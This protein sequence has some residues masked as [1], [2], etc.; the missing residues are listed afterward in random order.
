M[1]AKKFTK[2]QTEQATTL[3][4][5]SLYQV[6]T[7]GQMPTVGGYK[8][9]NRLAL[10]LLIPH[11][12]V[13]YK[14]SSNG[15]YVQIFNSYP[16]PDRSEGFQDFLKNKLTKDDIDNE[17][18][19]L[20]DTGY[21]LL[22][23]QVKRIED[24]S[25]GEE[26]VDFF[27]SPYPNGS[28][29]QI[30]VNLLENGF[31]QRKEPLFKEI[32]RENFWRDIL[33]PIVRTRYLVKTPTPCYEEKQ[34]VYGGEE[35]DEFYSDM[36]SPGY[37]RFAD[38]I[39]LKKNNSASPPNICYFVRDFDFP[40]TGFPRYKGLYTYQVRMII[41]E[42]QAKHFAVA[43]A[44]IREAV[45]DST[46]EYW[47]FEGR[48][49]HHFYDDSYKQLFLDLLIPLDKSLEEKSIKRII[50]ILKTPYHPKV[51][52][53]V[54]P[55]FTS[56][57][58]DIRREALSTKLGLDRL[59]KSFE[60][61]NSE[62]SR[63][64]KIRIAALFYLFSIMPQNFSKRS[65]TADSRVSCMIK[66]VRIGPSP[67]MCSVT[68]SEFPDEK[69]EV[70]TNWEYY[71]RFYHDIANTQARRIR[72]RVQYRYHQAI[73]KAMYN[74]LDFPMGL[75]QIKSAANSK[76]DSLCKYYPY[77]LIQIDFKDSKS[78]ELLKANSRKTV[79]KCNGVEKYRE[80]IEPIHFPIGGKLD[81]YLTIKWYENPNFPSHIGSDI[82][83][84]PTLIR[85]AIKNS[86]GRSL[87]DFMK[88]EVEDRE[89]A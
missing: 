56:S 61:E 89:N 70:F 4:K 68:F 18:I 54:D 28:S 14:K 22:L 38:S 43:L 29:R 5:S 47:K 66:P 9:L 81:N 35:V 27:F 41:P 87:A 37:E 86:V 88:R 79:S 49:L 80:D 40:V 51:R 45:R 46:N 20:F 24:K 6:L 71:Y 55:A 72:V 73:E 59:E 62:E 83:E 85:K 33:A 67:W 12:F 42:L 77:R 75:P 1:A 23:V 50:D 11:K 64:E 8:F 74:S 2:R 31:D 48:K 10:S 84:N 65:Q 26:G 76:F 78:I 16:D 60:S 21:Y 15:E 25:Q 30:V 63:N 69:D 44:A 57:F 82:V 34:S 36:I 13:L 39:L 19:E 32:Y 52:C 3:I 17:A 53:F 58:L 7:Q